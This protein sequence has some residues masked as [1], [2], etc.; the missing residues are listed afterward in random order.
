[1]NHEA[2]DALGREI[3]MTYF[4][5]QDKHRFAVGEFAGDLRG[6]ERLVDEW[7][8][9]YKEWE[10]QDTLAVAYSESRL[11]CK[12]T[13]DMSEPLNVRN[14]APGQGES[15]KDLYRKDT[16]GNT[17]LYPNSLIAK[18][19]ASIVGRMKP[20]AFLDG[21]KARLGYHDLS[22]LVLN[23]AKGIS[24]QQYKTVTSGQVYGFMPIAPSIDQCVF[25]NINAAAKLKRDSHPDFYQKVVDIRNRM[26]RIKLA[27][28]NDMKTVFIRVGTTK[29]GHDKFK[30][31]IGMKTDVS[32]NDVADNLVD[33]SK[34]RAG[35]NTANVTTTPAIYEA[36]RNA[37]INY[38]AMIKR[39]LGKY[40]EVS[41][42]YR[43]HA[44]NVSTGR[45]VFPVF[46]QF[47]STSQRWTVGDVNNQSVWSARQ[48]AEFFSDMPLV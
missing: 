37:A 1:M 25:Q 26:T 23:P 11:T 46:A 3:L 24:K 32:K 16:W 38:E 13:S 7:W 21:N 43:Q 30:Y 9:A 42:A 22:A 39:M 14:V 48:P 28:G 8:L 2:C 35:A 18:T 33:E 36:R 15:I 29:L 17:S 12:G 41:I 4:Q 27:S 5:Y 47:D 19:N 34:F 44:R 20:E 10:Q 40:A 31:V 45:I 6:L